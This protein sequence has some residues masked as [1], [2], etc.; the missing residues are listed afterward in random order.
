MSFIKI[1]SIVVTLSLCFFQ[2][3]SSATTENSSSTRKDLSSNDTVS[4][5]SVEE[6]LENSYSQVVSQPQKGTLVFDISYSTR[7]YLDSKSA[8]FRGVISQFGRLLNVKDFFLYGNTVQPANDF[9]NLL[10]TGNFTWSTGSDINS[11]LRFMLEKVRSTNDVVCLISDGIMSGTNEQIRHNSEFN[12]Q[13][14]E[15]LMNQIKNSIETLDSTYSALI[16]RY[17]APFQGTYYAYNNRNINLNCNRP[18]FAI[19]LGKWEKI[20]W[21]EQDLI[22]GKTNEKDESYYKYSDLIMLAD[23]KSYKKCFFTHKYGIN[24]R[25]GQYSI[26]RNDSVVFSCS[27]KD[28][29]PYMQTE[30]YF[31]KNFQLLKQRRGQSEFALIP[32]DKYQFY[33][34]RQRQKVIISFTN[35]AISTYI[36]NN[37][38]QFK[39]KYSLPEWVG[40]FSDED[41]AGIA[42]NAVKKNQTFNLKY[43]VNGF[44]ELNGSEN[45]ILTEMNFYFKK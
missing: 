13:N 24:H 3:C 20:K 18:Y 36:S 25:N 37:L 33:I 16:V 27:I 30:S 9:M 19:I 4:A 40:N 11:M 21:I 5:Y 26:Q 29:P 44:S 7:G 42:T 32:K 8:N 31:D 1:F 34:D 6:S 43:L 35:V 2:S 23:T 17:T 45:V 41:D 38:L 22:Q 12:I 14:K 28:L 39:L 10:N 15:V